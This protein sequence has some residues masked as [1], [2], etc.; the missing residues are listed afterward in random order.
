MDL[1][2]HLADLRQRQQRVW[3]AEVPR[4]VVY[5]QGEQSI[6]EHLRTWA[7]RTPNRTAIAFYGREIDYAELDELSDRFA[8]WLE[9]VGVAPGDR[10][11]MA[12]YKIPRFRIVEEM[13]MTTTG[14]I[15]KGELLEVAQ[16]MAAKA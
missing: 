4:E 1:D 8:G 12:P 2:G 13:P 9:S 15:K 7:R 14:T 16:Q 10:Q 11:N 5:P 3:P 6:T